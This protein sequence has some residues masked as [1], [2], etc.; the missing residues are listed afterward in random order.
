MLKY[1]VN[2]LIDIVFSLG[3]G[4]Y[5]DDIELRYS[6]RSIEK[7]L[8]NYRNIYIVGELPHWIKN[9]T[10]VKIKDHA[11]LENKERNIY[12]KICAAC[13]IPGLS[14]DFIFF[15]DDHFLLQD[16]EAHQF[17]YHHKGFMDNE[18]RKYGESYLITLKNT[19]HL[20]TGTNNFD[21]HCPIIYNK[22]KFLS[23]PL[24][25]KPY[26]YCLKTCYCNLNN[27]E[28]EY[29]EDCK[30]KPALN[31]ETF[32]SVIK[33]RIYFSIDNGAFKGE[34]LKVLEYLYP[35]KSKYE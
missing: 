22:K 4:S 20:F 32:M 10:H 2:N 8:K 26:G 1:L 29:Y 25:W 16:I 15:N 5:K 7:H 34:L 28:G 12:R 23:M 11:G 21:T 18:G 13:E 33:D 3:K 17:P 9:V 6:L 14:E 24:K 35:V 31:F 27:I 19:M 30:I